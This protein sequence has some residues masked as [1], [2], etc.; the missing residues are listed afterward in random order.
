LLESAAAEA[1]K[2]ARKAGDREYRFPR[3]RLYDLRITAI[4]NLKAA[5]VPMDVVH[6]LAGHA[7]L[8][9]TMRYYN[10]PSDERRRAAAASVSKWLQG[11]AVATR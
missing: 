10:K 5:G 7:N 2:A 1:E 9:T 11:R 6:V 3:T 4:E 8:Q